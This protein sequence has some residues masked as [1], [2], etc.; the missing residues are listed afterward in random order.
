MENVVKQLEKLSKRM[1]ISLQIVIQD[2]SSCCIEEFW[3]EDVIHSFENVKELVNFLNEE[4][5][6]RVEKCPKC[7]SGIRCMTKQGRQCTRCNEFY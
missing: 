4:T 2:D 1:N 6:K 5:V 3:S 7:G